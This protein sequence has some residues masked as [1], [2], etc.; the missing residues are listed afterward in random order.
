MTA[1]YLTES[2]FPAKSGQTAL[3]HAAADGLG[4]L[5]TQMLDAKGVRVIGTVSTVEK[6]RLAKVPLLGRPFRAEN[7]AATAR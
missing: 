7:G 3:V 5:L 4:L 2:T 6:A 1:H